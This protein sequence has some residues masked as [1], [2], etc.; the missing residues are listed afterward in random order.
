[1]QVQGPI[2]KGEWADPFNLKDGD[3][4]YLYPTKNSEK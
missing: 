1:M 2:I 4:Y 3:D